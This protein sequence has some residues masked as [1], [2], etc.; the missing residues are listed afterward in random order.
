MTTLD[1]Y[2]KAIIKQKRKAGLRKSRKIYATKS[3]K[4]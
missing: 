2:S 3:I 4:N 1:M